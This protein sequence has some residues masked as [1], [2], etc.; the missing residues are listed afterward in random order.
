[1]ADSADTSVSAASSGARPSLPVSSGEK[2]PDSEGTSAALRDSDS[3]AAST[4]LRVDFYV[5]EE[6]SAS[7][8][9]KLACRLAEKAYLAGQSALVWHTDPA[10]LKVF[11]EL[12]WTF[13]D[14][15]FVPHEMVAA[16]ATR[17]E[18]PVLLSAGTAPPTSVDIIINLSPDIPACLAQSSRIAEII[19]GDDG[20]RRAGRAR[21]KAYRDLGVQPASHNIRGE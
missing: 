8:R 15:S 10:E 5:L 1:M 21:F 13:M 19:D 9:L 17:S 7:S 3:Q 18:T 14:G 12:L 2:A 16:G 4:A 20:R 11:D 6:A